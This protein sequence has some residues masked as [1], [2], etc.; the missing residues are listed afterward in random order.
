MGGSTVPGGRS[1]SIVR[2]RCAIQ[3]GVDKHA[4]VCFVFGGWRSKGHAVP[5]IL[6]GLSM[7]AAEDYPPASECSF[8][9]CGGA[10]G[11]LTDNRTPPGKL[12]AILPVLIECWCSGSSNC[13]CRLPYPPTL[14]GI[15][16]EPHP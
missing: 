8:H 12:R 2:Q 7:N 4:R 13:H 6:R 1:G 3:C 10:I 9:N 5:P 11:I 16:A 15:E 14:R